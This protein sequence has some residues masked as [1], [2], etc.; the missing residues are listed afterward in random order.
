[1]NE[2]PRFLSVARVAEALDGIS[3]MTLYREI[4]AGRFPAIRVGRRLFVPAE[5]LPA[6]RDRAMASWQVV[7]A[8]DWVAATAA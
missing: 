3:E 2:V 4:K 7:N 8:A 1:M 5:A 6:M